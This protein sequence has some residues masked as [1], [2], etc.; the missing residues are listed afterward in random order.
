MLGLRHRAGASHCQPTLTHRIARADCA[1]WAMQRAQR[2]ESAPLAA[3]VERADY[4]RVAR[5]AEF[6][7]RGRREQPQR[8]WRAAELHES[9]AFGPA[10]RGVLH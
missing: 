9:P 2:V 7:G 8:K 5:D 1:G 3:L 6:R 10:L 4:G